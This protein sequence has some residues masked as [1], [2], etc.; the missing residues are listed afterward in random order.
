MSIIVPLLL[1]GGGVGDGGL[2]VRR[3]AFDTRVFPAAA[4]KGL[5]LV[6]GT[7]QK[8][9]TP[10]LKGDGAHIAFEHRCDAL[11]PLNSGRPPLARVAWGGPDSLGG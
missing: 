8:H 6:L 2:G 11:T 10:V 1:L 9:P 4:A 7:L 5:R 3:M